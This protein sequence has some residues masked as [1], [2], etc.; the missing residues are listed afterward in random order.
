MIRTK[1][2]RTIGA[3]LAIFYAG[4]NVRGGGW[5]TVAASFAIVLALTYLAV[6]WAPRKP[7]T[8]ALAVLVLVLLIAGLAGCD[9]DNAS[10][11]PVTNPP[12]AV[13]I[14]ALGESSSNWDS[15]KCVIGIGATGFGIFTTVGSDGLLAVLGWGFT[16]WGAA[17]TTA[18]CW[19]A[20]ANDVWS[21]ITIAFTCDGHS[22]FPVTFNKFV[23][24]RNFMS[25]Y[26]CV[27]I[28]TWAVFLAAEAAYLVTS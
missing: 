22:V 10:T 19:Q 17:L 26:K 12:R 4:L 18:D 9:L 25:N 16:G 13:A 14:V 1:W 20:A 11:A 24:V 8:K 28:A 27:P 6:L 2:F 5:L 15:A 21:P 23:D 7:P 3:C